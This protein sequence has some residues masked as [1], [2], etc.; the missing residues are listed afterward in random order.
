MEA[1]SILGIFDFVIGFIDKFPFFMVV[2][3]E[4]QNME[5]FPTTL[6]LFFFGEDGKGTLTHE[7]FYD[8]MHNLQSEGELQAYNRDCS[9]NQTLS[10]V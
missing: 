6:S 3:Q 5:R 8:F 2:V 10:T 1:V 4:R 7:N 9:V